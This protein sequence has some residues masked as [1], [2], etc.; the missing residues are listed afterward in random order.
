MPITDAMEGRDG[1]DGTNG[2]NGAA[3]TPNTPVVVTPTFG[4]AAQ[5]ADPA[6]PALI[7]I[8]ARATY[9]ITLAATFTD[10]VEL[11]IG[12]VAADVAAGTGASIKVAEAIFGVTGIALTVG[13][14][15]DQENQLVATLPI[16]WYYAVRRTNG[17]RAVIGPC[18]SQPLS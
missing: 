17:T 4:V 10:T 18:V 2:I 7:S 14:A 8:M 9:N 15:L 13:M 16:G 3:F 11:R 12:A 6:K 1:T 5:A